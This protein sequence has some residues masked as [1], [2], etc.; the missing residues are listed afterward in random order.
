MR[1]RYALAARVHISETAHVD[2]SVER[3]RLALDAQLPQQP[4]HVL[5]ERL[6][7]ADVIDGSAI[8]WKDIKFDR[9]RPDVVAIVAYG[10][11]TPHVIDKC[12]KPALVGV[13]P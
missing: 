3:R 12:L 2:G 11:T 9:L 4:L 5:S 6:D 10:A 1:H 7:T 8:S 13:S